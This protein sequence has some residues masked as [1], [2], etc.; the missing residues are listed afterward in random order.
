MSNAQPV[1]EQ[2]VKRKH[3]SQFNREKLYIVGLLLLGDHLSKRHHD[4][5]QC[6]KGKFAGL[7]FDLHFPYAGDAQ[8]ELVISITTDFSYRCR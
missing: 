6:R 1:P 3:V 5:F 7:Y 8:V 2:R 4:R